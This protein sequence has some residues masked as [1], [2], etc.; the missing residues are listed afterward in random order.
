M[1]SVKRFQLIQA[2]LRAY[3][4][5]CL[6]D[7]NAADD[8]VQETALA[9][10]RHPDRAF[11]NPE[12]WGILKHKV[13]DQLRRRLRRLGEQSKSEAADAA[14]LSELPAADSTDAGLRAERREVIES[15]QR[16][17]L[18]L[19]AQDRLI[20]YLRFFEN[21]TLEAIAL[22]QGVA[23]TTVHEKIRRALASLTR[24]LP[25]PSER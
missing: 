4:R 24:R 11:S 16:A 1:S 6:R 13:I 14:E 23:T 19:P 3:A 7:H 5:R 18:S 22:H 20:I 10:L 9:I 2:D 25:P 8:A 21:W 12:I 17:I 15:V